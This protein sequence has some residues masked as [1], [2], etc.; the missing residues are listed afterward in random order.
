MNQ[1]G[2]YTHNFLHFAFSCGLDDTNINTIVIFS[3]SQYEELNHAVVVVGYGTIKDKPYWLVKNSWGNIWGLNGYCL[4]S[5]RKNNC[6]V[7]TDAT[8]VTFE[9]KEQI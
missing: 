7:L 2:T 5:A 3:K 6:G 4:M 8:Y 1:N 9:N